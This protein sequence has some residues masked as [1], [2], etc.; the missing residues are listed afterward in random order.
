MP[1]TDYLN[2]RIEALERE[3]RRLTQLIEQREKNVRGFL[4][5]INDPIFDKPLNRLPGQP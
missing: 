2:A 5:D 1:Q 4:T 3:N